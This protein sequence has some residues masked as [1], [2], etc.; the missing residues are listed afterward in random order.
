MSNSEL[1]AVIEKLLIVSKLKYH[2]QMVERTEK[3]VTK[4][5]WI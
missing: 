2:T 4:L 1:F 5:A 3:E